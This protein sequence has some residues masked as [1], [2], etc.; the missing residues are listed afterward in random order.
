MP[1][2]SFS[3]FL[4]DTLEISASGQT[5]DTNGGIIYSSYLKST[6]DV[7]LQPLNSD[8]M[9]TFAQDGIIATHIAYTDAVVDV[10]AGDIASDGTYTYDI[11]GWRN[12]GGNNPAGTVF[13]MYLRIR[14]SDP[15]STS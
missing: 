15:G 8:K 10:K 9:R 7:S 6:V 13:E 12:R 4:L 14:H 3:E 11:T 2:F 5:L 1:S